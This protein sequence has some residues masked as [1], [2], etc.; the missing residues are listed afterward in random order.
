MD[1]DCVLAACCFLAAS[2]VPGMQGFR[3]TGLLTG[4]LPL[5]A[6]CILKQSY[7]TFW[8]SHKVALQFSSIAPQHTVIDT[9]S[10]V[11]RFIVS[12]QDGRDERHFILQLTFSRFPVIF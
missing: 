10:S 2:C 4:L 5:V 6:F 1:P 11:L 12:F 8:G 7:A 3:L 9:L